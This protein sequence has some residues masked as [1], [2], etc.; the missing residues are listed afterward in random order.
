[1]LIDAHAHFATPD[2][3]PARAHVRT[4]FC[5]TDPASAA[6]ALS[7]RGENR[8]A[9]CALHPWYADR[10][11]V[12]EL[13]PF[14]RESTALCDAD[15]L[16]LD[17]PFGALDVISRGDMQDWLASMKTHLGRTCLLVTH[18]IDEAIYLSDRI[19]VL[20]GRPAAIHREYRVTE[21][22]RTRDWLYAQGALRHSL[23]DSIRGLEAGPC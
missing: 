19:L 7:L 15:I 11:T 20:T 12:A 18:D 10:F 3:L 16:L 6:T 2:E 5:G 22:N 14:I 4:V 8:L 23:H 9:A 1:M 21:A 13:L 17:E